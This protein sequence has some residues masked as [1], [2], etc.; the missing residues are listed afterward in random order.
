MP[1]FNTQDI[2]RP[3]YGGPHEPTH[4]P[5]RGSLFVASIYGALKGITWKSRVMIGVGTTGGME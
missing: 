1:C 2:L 5:L 4:P 3:W